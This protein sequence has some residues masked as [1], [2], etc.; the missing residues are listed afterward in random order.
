[1]FHYIFKLKLKQTSQTS[2]FFT[3]EIVNI[4]LSHL[5]ESH[6]QQHVNRSGAGERDVVDLLVVRLHDELA[7]R[8][9]AVS[10]NLQEVETTAA[11]RTTTTTTD[12]VC[13]ETHC[14]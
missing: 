9:A 13:D 5:I 7:Q 12:P 11:Q 14:V 8:A 3:N 6:L 2:F 4:I 1:M 10:V